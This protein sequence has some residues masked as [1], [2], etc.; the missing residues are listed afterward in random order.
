MSYVFPPLTLPLDQMSCIDLKDMS[1]EY[2]P[3]VLVKT[4][5]WE[6]PSHLVDSAF[7]L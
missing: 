7:H 1:D 5:G 4:G 2:P 3:S 6:A